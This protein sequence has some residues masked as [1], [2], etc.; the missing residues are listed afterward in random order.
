MP[1]VA[2][3]G[4]SNADSYATLAEA[5]A[6]HGVSLYSTVWDAATDV[7]Q[8]KA[9]K[10]ATRLLDA[11][12]VWLGSRTYADQALGFPRTG[13]FRDTTVV[14][15]SATI[16]VEI[17]NATAEF[18]QYL[19]ANNPNTPNGIAVQGIT[20]VKAGPI[21]VQFKDVIESKVVPDHILL[22]IP[23]AWY[24]GGIIEDDLTT[25]IFEVV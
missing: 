25:A 17:R 3:P 24:E 13:L 9:L 11:Y 5:D 18:G 4:A 1:I 16:P 23:K 22:M 2:T 12:F 10:M 15:D 19:L 8:E 21:E 7:N 20:K 14:V 6:Y